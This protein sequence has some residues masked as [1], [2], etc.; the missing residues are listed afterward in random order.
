VA[1]GGQLVAVIGLQVARSIIRAAW[2]G[3][4]R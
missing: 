1:G 4:D 3:A 2:P